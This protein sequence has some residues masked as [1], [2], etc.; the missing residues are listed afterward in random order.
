MHNDK[1]LWANSAKSSSAKNFAVW[2]WSEREEGDRKSFSLLQL[3]V[4]KQAAL[5]KKSISSA[6]WQN[7]KQTV[8]WVL[9]FCS[10]L[11]FIVLRVGSS[12]PTILWAD[13]ATCATSF[14]YSTVQLEYHTLIQWQRVVLWR[15]CK[16]CPVAEKKVLPLLVCWGRRVSAVLSSPGGRCSGT[17]LDLL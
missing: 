2:G 7:D 13:L 12:F 17:M 9:F 8:T 3:W 14:L 4:G 15:W 10:Q 6:W 5:G 1:R 11:A 16:N